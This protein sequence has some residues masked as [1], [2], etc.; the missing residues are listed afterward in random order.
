MNEFKKLAV[1]ILL[2]IVIDVVIIMNEGWLGFLFVV[3]EI[4]YGVNEVFRRINNGEE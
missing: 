1:I 3:I 2:L 4:L